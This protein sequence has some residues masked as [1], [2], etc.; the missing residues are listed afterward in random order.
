MIEKAQKHSQT[1]E[2]TT[3]LKLLSQTAV[4]YQTWKA[5]QA[6][7][8]HTYHSSSHVSTIARRSSP[9]K[10]N[11]IHNVPKC[12]CK[13]AVIKT[14]P[15]QQQSCWLRNFHRRSMIHLVLCVG[16]KQRFPARMTQSW[17]VG[18]YESILLPSIYRETALQIHQERHRGSAV[19]WATSTH[20]SKSHGT[21]CLS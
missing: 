5:A 14:L 15:L 13:H 1:E 19:S 4:F 7:H 8:V 11:M 3:L 21:L 16:L 12:H 6:V 20:P 18:H 9:G 2:H 10:Q 17:H